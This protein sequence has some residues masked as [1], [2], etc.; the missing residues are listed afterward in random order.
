MEFNE[1]WRTLVMVATRC[2]VPQVVVLKGDY[3]GFADANNKK[4]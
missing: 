3:D 4:P 2:G 1:L